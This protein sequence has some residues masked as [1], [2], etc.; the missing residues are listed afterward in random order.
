MWSPTPSCRP[1]TSCRVSAVIVPPSYRAPV[2]TAR[3]RYRAD[4]GAPGAPA[5]AASLERAPDRRGRLAHV[6]QLREGGGAAEVAKTAVG[7]DQQPV[8]GHHLAPAADPGLDL[9]SR[10]HLQVLG[11]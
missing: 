10:F 7:R 3:G 8:G 9:L 5:R 11:V 2:V 1:S 4:R 6:A